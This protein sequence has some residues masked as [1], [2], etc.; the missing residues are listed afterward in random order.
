[1]T[2]V[3]RGPAAFD[4]S[5]AELYRKLLEQFYEDSVGRYGLDHEQVRMLSRLLSKDGSAGPDSASS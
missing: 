2:D 4:P 5:K 3:S 1:V